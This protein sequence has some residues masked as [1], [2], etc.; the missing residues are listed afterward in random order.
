MST[1][2]IAPRLVLDA[3]L[4]RQA[5]RGLLSSPGAA[6]RLPEVAHWQA[7]VNFYTYP[8]AM[9]D[10]NDP[11]STGTFRTKT[12]PTG[13]T[14][15]DAFDAFVAYLGNFCSSLGIGGTWDAWRR[16]TDAAMDAR[17]SWALERQL[18]WGT[19]VAGNPYLADADV[20]LPGGAGAK[21]AAVA[22][23][24][25][26]G[27]LAE[28]GQA[29]VIHATP[30]VVSFLGADNF[31]PDGPQLRTLSGTPVIVG[32]G[33]SDLAG[34]DNLAPAGGSE[35]AAGQSWI[36]AS[37]PIIYREGAVISLPETMGEALDRSDNSVIYRAERD[38]WVAFDGGPHAAVLADWSP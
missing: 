31:T 11:C 16:R 23:A 28:R 8:A 26:E 9:P 21:A 38:L 20:S 35:A 1:T 32:Q 27:F 24:Y 18:A 3:P 12:V 4:P 7:G 33:Y 25:L 19:F 34:A 15:P 17:T 37:S 30:E 13:V 5:P 14:L 6:L 29:G 22:L 10:A 36:F 2:G